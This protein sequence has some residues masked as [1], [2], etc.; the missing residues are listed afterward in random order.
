MKFKLTVLSL[1][2]GGVLLA[3]FALAQPPGSFKPMP[4]P[5]AGKAPKPSAPPKDQRDYIFEGYK[6]KLPDRTPRSMP[7]TPEMTAPAQP[8]IVSPHKDPTRFPPKVPGP[9]FPKI[10]D[11]LTKKPQPKY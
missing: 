10:P 3:T 11:D 7:S 8:A 1:L 9:T 4:R 6:P 5:Q 2:T